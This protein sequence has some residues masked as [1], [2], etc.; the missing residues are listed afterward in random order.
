MGSNP[1]LSAV[2]ELIAEHTEP[3]L[4]IDPDSSGSQPKG[5]QRGFR[6]PSRSEVCRARHPRSVELLGRGHPAAAG[7]VPERPNGRD[8]KSRVLCKRDHGFESHPLR[9]RNGLS[10]VRHFGRLSTGPEIVDGPC[11]RRALPSLRSG[12][13]RDKAPPIAVAPGLHDRPSGQRQTP[14]YDLGVATEE[15]RGDQPAARADR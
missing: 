7:E 10:P 3:V 8:W 1:T 12:P 14:L 5:P 9:H 2:G 13:G 11:L 6:I 4:S 15:S